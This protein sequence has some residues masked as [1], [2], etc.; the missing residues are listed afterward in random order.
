MLRLDINLLLN[1]INILILYV[2]FKKFLFKPVNNIIAKRKAEIEQGFAQVEDAK[3]EAEK[4]RS[5]QDGIIAAAKEESGR[6][7]ADARAKAKEEYN[8]ILAR[9]EE[10]AKRTVKKAQLEIEADKKRT[11]KEMESQIAGLVMA[12]TEKVVGEKYDSEKDLMLYD[13]FLAEVG[14]GYDADDN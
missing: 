1:L 8:R 5:E 6:I 13:K 11:M 4:I 3:A 2:G 7:V 9:A 12:A 14:E 10:D